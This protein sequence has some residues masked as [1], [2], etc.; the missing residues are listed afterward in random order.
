MGELVD[1]E[2]LEDAGDVR[3]G[4]DLD[5]RAA[6]AEAMGRLELVADARPDTTAVTVR[7]DPDLT[8][9]ALVATLEGWR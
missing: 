6:V 1:V 9:A 8:L 3:G 2:Q 7:A 5:V 4:V